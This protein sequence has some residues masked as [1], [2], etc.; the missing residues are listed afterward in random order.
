MLFSNYALVLLLPTKDSVWQRS[1][2]AWPV[3]FLA[4]FLPAEALFW[5]LKVVVSRAKCITS[6]RLL[7]E[8]KH[9]LFG[10]DSKE[11]R[12]KQPV[13]GQGAFL[14]FPLPLP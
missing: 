13:Q 7:A 2:V 11:T 3:C 12:S 8:R 9:V 10:G 6:P 5:S 1:L 4:F 14:P